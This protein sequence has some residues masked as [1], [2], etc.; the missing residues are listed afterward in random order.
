MS[1]R[2]EARARTLQALYAYELSGDEAAH[3]LQHVLRPA[4]QDDPAALRF[5]EQLFFRTI[6]HLGEADALIARIVDN[7]EISRLAALDRIVLR[8]ALTEMLAFEDIP[9]K[10]TINEAIEV[11]K[12]FSTEQSGTFVNGVLDAAL[13]VLQAEGRLRKSGRGLLNTTPPRRRAPTETQAG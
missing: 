8:M 6:D 12:A 10:V 4:L 9:P 2:R 13:R 5:A 3:V 11:A 7:W 1:T